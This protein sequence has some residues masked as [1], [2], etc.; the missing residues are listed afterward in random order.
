MGWHGYGLFKWVVHLVTD[1]VAI[2]HKNDYKSSFRKLLFLS[3]ASYPLKVPASHHQMGAYSTPHIQHHIQHHKQHHIQ[4]HIQ[5]HMLRSTDWES[6]GNVHNQ[7]VY[8][9]S[10]V[11]TWNRISFPLK[12]NNN[13]AWSLG[14]ANLPFK[15]IGVH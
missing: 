15:I 13:T 1:S 10:S 9:Y 12:Q 4:Y 7:N 8:T 14:T 11:Y 6:G 2:V 5:H 3:I